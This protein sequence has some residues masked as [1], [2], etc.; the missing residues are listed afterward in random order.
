MAEPDVRVDPVLLEAAGAVVARVGG[1]V[2]AAALAAEP[3]VT[4]QPAW[5]PGFDSVAAAAALAAADLVAVRALGAGLVDCAN[6][7][8]TAAAAWAESERV[9]ADGLRT[10]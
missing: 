3:A 7:M 10:G 9:I 6:A 5:E 8:H 4:P 1:D 2:A